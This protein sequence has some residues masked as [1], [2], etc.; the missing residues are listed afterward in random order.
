M[1]INLS[2]PFSYSTGSIERLPFPYPVFPQLVS[3]CSLQGNASAFLSLAYP[4]ILDE[5]SKKWNGNPLTNFYLIPRTHW[6]LCTPNNPFR[7]E[8]ESLYTMRPKASW[9]HEISEIKHQEWNWMDSCGDALFHFFHVK[10]FISPKPKSCSIPIN[11][12]SLRENPQ[13]RSYEVRLA[14]LKRKRVW[15]ETKA[16]SV[17][18]KG[19]LRGTLSLNPLNTDLKPLWRL[20]TCHIGK[21]KIPLNPHGLQ[22][23][24]FSYMKRLKRIGNRGTL[25]LKFP[26]HR[27]RILFKKASPARPHKPRS[28]G[29]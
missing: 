26:R 27:H 18:L 19:L 22:I 10:C 5:N 4:I 6:C 2:L 20:L 1:A 11:K 14:G 15:D 9:K 7:I 17:D 25:R 24:H 23:C 21:G 12:G 8:R 29:G 16:L 3:E 13:R 28:P